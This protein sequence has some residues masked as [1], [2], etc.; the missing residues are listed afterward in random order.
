MQQDLTALTAAVQKNTDAEASAI[1]AIKGLADQ[2]AALQVSD[3]AVQAQIDALAAEISSGA[4][5]LGAAVTASTPAAPPVDTP[6]VDN[7]PVDTPP[8]DTG[9]GTGD[10]P[11]APD[12][13]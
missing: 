9:T 1:Q 7:P 3:P 8:V 6:P 4:E 11:P 2:V 13:P 12:V 5:A 10:T